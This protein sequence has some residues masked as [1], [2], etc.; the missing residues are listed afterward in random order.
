MSAKHTATP[1]HCKRLIGVVDRGFALF[2][3][4]E[5]GTT[6]TTHRIDDNGEFAKEDAEF[7]VRACNAYDDSMKALQ[8]TL[9]GLESGNVKSKPIIDFGDENAE[10]LPMMS[11]EQVIRAAIAKGGAA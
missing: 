2:R 6:K 9:S 8:L 10:N 7:I 11:L 1:W 3:T 4:K 5:S